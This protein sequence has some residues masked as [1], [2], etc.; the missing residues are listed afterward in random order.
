MVALLAIATH[1]CPQASLVEESIAKVIREK[2]GAQLSKEAYSDLFVYC[3]PKFVSPVVPDF[4]VPATLP[5]ENAYKH[6]VHMLEQELSCQST[7]R[8]LR[9]Y[10]KLYTSIALSK[11]VSFG[12]DELTLTAL[13]LK[14]RQLESTDVPSLKNATCKSALDIHYYLEDE[15]TVHVDAA[16]KQRR[17][18]NY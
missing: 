4:S 17:F 3:S 13:K 7:F 16:E 11:L 15:D 8:K 18:E 10:L 5:T 6:Q 2:H 14:L 9:S 12:N 1:L